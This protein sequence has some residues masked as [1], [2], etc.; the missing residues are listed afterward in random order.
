[1]S[2]EYIAPPPYYSSP[3]HHHANNPGYYRQPLSVDKRD[4]LDDKPPH[5]DPTDAEMLAEAQQQNHPSTKDSD[6]SE[7]ALLD[8]SLSWIA[9]ANRQ[10]RTGVHAPLAVS[11]ENPPRFV[12]S[13]TSHPE[14]APGRDTAN[15]TGV[16]ITL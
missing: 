4:N 7:Q 2:Y 14:L 9:N 1:M 10:Q 8:E 5:L 11:I 16:A 12:F 3:P 13:K 6:P 15:G